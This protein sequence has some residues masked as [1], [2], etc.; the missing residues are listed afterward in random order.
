M[1]IHSPTRLRAT[2]PLCDPRLEDM[3]YGVSTALIGLLSVLLATNQVVAASNYVAQTTG[4]SI[5]VVD[6]NDPVEKEYQKLL[7]MDD[8]AIAD[9]DKMI[10]DNKAFQEKG[11]G[12]QDA[13]L[14]AKMEQKLEPIQTAYQDFLLRNPNH[15]RARLA[16]GSFLDQLGKESEAAEQWEKVRQIDP[17][18]PAAWNNM[19]NYYGHRGPITNAFKYYE[20]AIELK[21]TE[22]IYL[23]NLATTV[24][25]FRE[26]A[27]EYYKLTEQQVFDRALELYRKALALDPGNFLL[28]NDLA[29]T[30][31]GIKPLRLEEG[32]AAWRETLK[33]AKDELQREG[34]YIH[35]A[36]YEINL[37]RYDEARQ[38]LSIITNATYSQLKERVSKNLQ[39]REARASKSSQTN[40][41]AATATN[42]VSK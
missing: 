3:F 39:E 23:Q 15:T 4:I 20:T 19:A 29:Q 2:Y 31:Y 5:P 42:A 7:E 8:A 41:P 10:S 33:L 24:F 11:A 12:L 26:D 9:A 35:L 17:K 21:P 14:T 36:R 25:L 37:G 28:A 38:H 22:P 40:T 1:V 32:L 18:N 13:L 6:P 27:Q 16:Y 34:V 30:Y